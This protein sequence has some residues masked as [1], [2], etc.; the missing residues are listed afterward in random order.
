MALT[1]CP[2]CQ[3]DVSTSATSCPNC[4]APVAAAAIEAKAAGAQLTTTQ[5]TSKKLKAQQLFAT[6]AVIVG[7]VWSM[8]GAESGSPV[9]GPLIMFSGLV[10]FIGVRIRIWW[11][12]S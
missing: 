10:W 4:G 8:G 6:L 3:K 7:L 11:H 12:H 5:G 9:V 2:D 1:T